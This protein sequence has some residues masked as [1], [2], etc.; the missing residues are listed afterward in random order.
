MLK[1][2]CAGNDCAELSENITD[3][4]I[5]PPPEKSCIGND[6]T[7]LS[8]NIT[9]VTILP[10][11]EELKPEPAIIEQNQTV[12]EEVTLEN[13]TESE[14]IVPQT[15]ALGIQGIS[16]LT[17]PVISSL[18]LNTTNVS[19]NN[20]LVNV[21]AYNVSNTATKIIWNWRRNDTPIAILNMPFEGINNTGANNAWDYSG[22]G[23]N[24]S[25]IGEIYWNSTVGYDGGGAYIFNWSPNHANKK[26]LVPGVTNHTIT[27]NFTLTLWINISASTDSAN[28]IVKGSSTTTASFVM[29]LEPTTFNFFGTAGGTWAGISDTY[30]YTRNKWTH[31]ALTYNNSG[32]QLYID[33]VRLGSPTGPGG[34]YPF[35]SSSDLQIGEG[36]FAGGNWNGTIDEV[37]IFNHSLS[38]EQ[39]HA[40]FNNKTNVIAAQETIRGENWTVIG[41]PNNRTGDGAPVTS[42]SV[43]ILSVIPTHSTPILNTTNMSSNRTEVNLTAYN[44]STADVDNDLVKNIYNWQVNG[45][46]IAVLNMPFG[47]D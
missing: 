40:L 14:V 3:V 1:S 36:S 15:A 2:P 18:I 11:P 24:G 4:A 7:G 35:S 26:I 17:A 34:V 6:C 9:D 28:P 27:S 13:S 38:A 33:G 42:N 32:G 5:I 20:T 47:R 16:I 25:D 23:N 45:N 43:R 29:Y 10:P 44:V 37:M 22:Y 30:T 8:E 31:V 19:I 12:I 39:I 41:Y 21:T 46:P